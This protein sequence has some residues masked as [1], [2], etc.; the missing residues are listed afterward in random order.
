VVSVNY[1]PSRAKIKYFPA[2][3][4]VY[5]FVGKN[6]AGSLGLETGIEGAG[7]SIS[8]HYELNVGDYVE[9]RVFP[10]PGLATD[11]LQID[12]NSPEFG[13]VKLP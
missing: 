7:Q 12:A 10:G 3:F 11:I 8:T 9:V 6:D 5:Q 13:M 1:T 4:A 2:V